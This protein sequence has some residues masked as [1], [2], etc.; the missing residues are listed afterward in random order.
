MFL[1]VEKNSRDGLSYLCLK[2]V[3]LLD[4]TVICL[5]GNDGS[6]P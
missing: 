4:V 6:R 1:I 2:K 3:Q 5:L